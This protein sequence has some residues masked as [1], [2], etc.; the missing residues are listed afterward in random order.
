MWLNLGS[1]KKPWAGRRSRYFGEWIKSNGGEPPSRVDRLSPRI[2]Q[3]RMARILVADTASQVPYSIVREI[4]SW[5]TGLTRRRRESHSNTQ[6]LH[7][8]RKA[9]GK[10]NVSRGLEKEHVK[11]SVLAGTEGTNQLNT[12]GRGD[13][14]HHPAKANLQ[15]STNMQ[16]FP[17]DEQCRG[18]T[19]WAISPSTLPSCL[20]C[21]SY[22]LYVLSTGESQCETCGVV[23]SK[24]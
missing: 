20:A 15:A 4:A 1:K 24:G 5:E 21:G 3:H 23:Q 14:N 16:P 9:S 12:Q 17:A 18:N 13:L 2:F 7:H 22:A 10:G 8:S 6:P 19:N 11:S